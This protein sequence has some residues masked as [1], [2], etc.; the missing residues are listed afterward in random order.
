MRGCT[1]SR[2]EQ[3]DTSPEMIEQELLPEVCRQTD[4][5]M[6]FKKKY[7]WHLCAHLTLPGK[8]LPLSD[9][10]VSLGHILD[11]QFQV[12]SETRNFVHNNSQ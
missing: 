12:H 1:V 9:L 5:E 3:F 11:D 7:L 6:L 4:R 10:S 2:Y 8:L